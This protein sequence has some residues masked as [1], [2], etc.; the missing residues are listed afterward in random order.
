MDIRSPTCHIGSHRDAGLLASA[1]DDLCFFL[2]L[3]CVEHAVGK[4]CI[5]KEAAQMFRRS[6]GAGADKDG[7]AFAMVL[8]NTIDHRFPSL[9]CFCIDTIR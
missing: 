6:D 1:R 8:R 9:F 5:R 4:P 3:P 2:I 7:P